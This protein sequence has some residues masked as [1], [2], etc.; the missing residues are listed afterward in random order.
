MKRTFFL[1][2]LIPLFGISQTKNV[3]NSTR[4]YCKPDKVMEFEKAL[5][6]HAQKYHTGDWKWRV[7]SIESGPDAG[8]YMVSEGPSN[9]TTID[10]R[11]DISTEH[12]NDWNKMV[13]PYLVGR[14]I[15][16]YTTFQPDM[17]TVQLTDYADKIII[18]HMTALPGKIFEMKALINKLKKVW[19][20]GKESNAVYSVSASGEPGYTLVSRLR[21]GYKELEDGYR[22]PM[23][24]RYNDI[25][26]ANAYDTYLKDYA[27]CVQNRWSEMLIYL[28]K[29]SSK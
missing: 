12:I 19:E 20:S 8:G 16:T 3:L 22:K 28:P 11:G 23:V 4:Y 21:G 27:G 7:W 10:G 26:G 15:S 24:D 5:S 18:T 13:A 17:S 9:W 2:L 6:T 14:A 25:Y 1:F 29:L